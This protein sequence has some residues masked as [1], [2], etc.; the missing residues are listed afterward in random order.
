MFT[1]IITEVGKVKSIIRE[2]LSA[3]LEITYKRIGESLS[4]GD[5]VAVNGACLSIVSRNSD[6]LFFDVI[7]NTLEKT[8]LKRLKAGSAVNLE[9]PLKLGDT[10]SGHMVSGHIDGERVIKSSRKTSAGW[11][12]DVGILPGDEKYLVDKCSVAVDGVSLTVGEL[13]R[14]FFRIFL[15]PHTLENTTLK[16]RRPGDY[17]NVEFDMMAKYAERNNR[18]SIT[19]NMLAEKGFI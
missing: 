4:P 9:S 16:S 6:S 5:S 2:G 13:S 1:G 15:I 11:V 19:R 10:L 3:R 12:L 7:G 18:G 8:A 14:A 17:V